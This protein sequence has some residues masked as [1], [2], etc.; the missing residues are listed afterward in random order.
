MSKDKSM[1][2]EDWNAWTADVRTWLSEVETHMAN[3]INAG[4]DEDM[5]EEMVEDIQKNLNRGDKRDT[6]RQINKQHIQDAG[7]DLAGWPKVR[8]GGSQL[9]PEVQ[10][11]QQTV[12]AGFEVA[13]TAYYNALEEAGLSHYEVTRASKKDGGTDGGP[14]ANVETFVKA[15]IASQKQTLTRDYNNGLWNGLDISDPVLRPYTGNDTSEDEED[16]AE[17]S[18]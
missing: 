14:Y 17:D 13:F 16:L 10:G 4:M 9:P 3:S 2:E 12:L 18:E 11:T 1:N 7:R 6:R 8:G 5:V 15:K